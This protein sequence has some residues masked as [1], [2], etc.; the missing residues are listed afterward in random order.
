MIVKK[1]FIICALF[2]CITMLIFI[3]I[4]YKM[5]SYMAIGSRVL[6]TSHPVPIN[7]HGIVRYITE[8]QYENLKMMWFAFIINLIIMGIFFYKAK[9]PYGRIGLDK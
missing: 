9:I 3:S 6:T 1:Y 5:D 2:M 4:M 7:E 8:A